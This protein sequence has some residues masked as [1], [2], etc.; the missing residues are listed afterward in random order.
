MWI[1]GGGYVGGDK[2]GS[3]NPSGLL[4]RSN[5]G[6]IFVEINYRLGALGWMG[7]SDVQNDG[8][9]NAGLWDQRLA[10]KWIQEHIAGL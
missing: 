6:I 2:A 7:G 10:L 1:F 5:N 3:G 4:A 8:D 9:A